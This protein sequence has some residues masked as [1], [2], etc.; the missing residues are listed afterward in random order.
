M[1]H[2]ETTP[3]VPQ[4]RLARE[5]R[6]RVEGLRTRARDKAQQSRVKRASGRMAAQRMH[7]L[8]QRYLGRI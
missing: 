3:G 8:Q 4:L 2:R 6:E 1:T 5:T 7:A